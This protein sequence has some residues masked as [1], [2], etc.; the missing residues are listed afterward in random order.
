MGARIQQAEQP[1]HVDGI[2]ER[3]YSGRGI[4]AGG[5]QDAARLPPTRKI[6]EIR[7]ARQ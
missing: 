1:A 7:L 6:V 3:R 4:D 5:G 2:I